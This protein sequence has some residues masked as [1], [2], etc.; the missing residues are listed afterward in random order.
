MRKVCLQD[1][2]EDGNELLTDERL[3]GGEEGE[4]TVAE[5]GLFV[6]GY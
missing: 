1:A 6:F 5:A 3:G 4:D 2:L